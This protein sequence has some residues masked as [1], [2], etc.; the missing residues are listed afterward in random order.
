MTLSDP[1]GVVGRIVDGRYRVERVVGHGGFGVVYRAQHLG[2]EAPIAL[3]L[4]KL[5]DEWSKQRR[6]SQVRSFQ[7]EGRVLFELSRLHPAI[8][9][10][11]ETG[12]VRSQDGSLSPYLALEWLEGVSL[13]QELKHRRALGLAPL[14]LPEVLAL[15]CAPAEGLAR[16]HGKGVAHRDIKP[17]NLFVAVR[18]GERHVKILDFGIA[19]LVNEAAE[20]TERLESTGGATASFTPMYAAPEQW[21]E[22]LGATGTWTDVHAFA[23]VLVELLTGRVPFAGRES[24]QLMAACLDAVRPT[25]GALGV[26]LGAEVEAVFA[27]ALALEPRDRFLDVGTLW[28]SLSAAAKWSPRDPAPPLELTSLQALAVADAPSLASR[29]SVA[30]DF[31]TTAGTAS[32]ARPRATPLTAPGSRWVSLLIGIGLAFAS[33]AA[34]AAYHVRERRSESVARLPTRVASKVSEPAIVV[35]PL[36]PPPAR[37][38]SAAVVSSPPERAPRRLSLASTKPSVDVG[39]VAA[40]APLDA[41]SPASPLS[42]A[43]FGPLPSTASAGARLPLNIDDPGLVH[44]R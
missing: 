43:S 22:R 2:F 40:R 34:A 41:P 19:K 5:P 8:V 9:R 15:M 10:A 4:L 29:R 28:S 25:P 23:L 12:S 36:P 11:F 44:R 21:L 24:A 18:D 30:P 14:T 33:A 37:S 38:A 39:A 35:T 17:G 42:T 1:F 16:A 7:R 13:A 27:R 3:K 32:W 26:G 20:T 6:D 31:D